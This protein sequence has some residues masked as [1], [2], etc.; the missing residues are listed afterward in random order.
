SSFDTSMVTDMRRMFEDCKSL[1]S[2]DLSSFD[3]SKGL[4]MRDMFAGCESLTDLD[5]VEF[6]KFL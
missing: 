5:P 4:D 3:T 2:L 6:R 1:T